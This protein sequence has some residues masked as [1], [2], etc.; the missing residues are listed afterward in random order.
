MITVDDA[1][2]LDGAEIDVAARVAWLLRMARTTA[3]GQLRLRA[4]AERLGTSAARLSRLETGQ[5]RDGRVVDGYETVLGLPEGSLRAPVD[6]LC[7]TFPAASPHDADPGSRIDDVRE[8]SRLTGTLQGDGPVTGGQ[9]LRWARAMAA[10]GNIG[11][12]EQQCRELLVRL[13]SEL[14]RA[15][16]HGYPSRYEALSLVRCSAYG[17]LVLD[18]AKQ[19]LRRPHAQGLGDLMSAVGEAV[20]DDALDW[21]LDLLL[22]ERGYAAQCGALAIENMG[23]I[24]ETD[25]WAA[26]APRLLEALERTPEGS[27][28]EEWATHLVRLVPPQVWR[29]NGL[30]PS[31]PLPPAAAL[32]RMGRDASNTV[33]HRCV[34]VAQEVGHETGVGEQPMLARLVH[35]ICFGHWETRAVT[36]YMLLAG[37][38]AIARAAGPH[39]AGLVEEAEDPRVRARG[40]RRLLGV[41]HGHDIP[42]VRRWLTDPD[43]GLRGSALAVTGAAGRQVDDEVLRAG[44]ADPETSRLA[45]Y[46]AGMSA[47]PALAEIAAAEDPDVR[48]AALWW[49]EHGGRV[50]E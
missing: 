11:M 44:L 20:T 33:W 24:G 39:M 4:L 35:D 6:V 48:N 3:G 21:C 9:W 5:L 42:P 26:V 45:L 27:P 50:A 16:S 25:F 2:A 32:P 40:A 49:L 23:Q 28:Q 12:P 30:V 41:L 8:L 10:P 18:V 22:D 36:A 15:V 31:R 13:A 43:P 19:E 17:H 47:H 38:P 14:A 46:S 1:T 7:R 29:E 34:A 37:V